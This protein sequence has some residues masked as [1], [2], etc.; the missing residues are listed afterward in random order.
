M[1]A[2]TCR[3][4]ASICASVNAS[5]RGV[6][7]D[8]EVSFTIRR[9]SRH[10]G[11]PAAT[12]RSAPPLQSHP[13]RIAVAVATCAGSGSPGSKGTMIAPHFRRPRNTRNHSGPFSSTIT[14]LCPVSP[15]PCTSCHSKAR[16][17]RSARLMRCPEATPMITAAPGSART[18]FSQAESSVALMSLRGAGAARSRLPRAR[19]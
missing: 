7:V 9:A 10:R 4:S 14:T 6:P 13:A 16:A 17:S 8:P 5:A 3:P 18:V 11:P 19:S 1:P 12:P 2:Q 15:A